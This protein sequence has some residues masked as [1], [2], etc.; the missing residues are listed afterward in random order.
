MKGRIEV[1]NGR[2]AMTRDFGR[3]ATS[4][5]LTAA[6]L[7]W[8]AGAH[9]PHGAGQRHAIESGG[10][11][12]AR[13]LQHVVDA[14]LAALLYHAARDRL[15]S[16]PADWRDVLKSA[17]LTARFAHSAFRDSANQVIDV[18]R[19]IG[20]PVTLLKGISIGDQ[21]YPAPHLR[22]MG[23]I[24]LLLSDR[25][26]PLV[27][28]TLLRLGFTPKADFRTGEGDPHGAP[29]LDPRRCVWIELHTALFHKK[30]R[31]NANS[32][33]RVDN[34]ARRSLASRFDGRSILRLSDELQLVYI[35]CYWLRDVTRN[36]MHPT[37]LIPVFD[38]IF[39][40]RARGRT[41]D[42][43][44]LLDSLDN[45]IAIASLYVL[46]AQVRR[47]GFDEDLAP[48]VRR[49]AVRQRIVGHAELRILNFLLESVLVTGKRFMGSFGDRH[50]M[51]ES[52]VMETLLMPGSFARK[53]LCLPWNV[54][55]PPSVPERYSVAYHGKR[56][57]RLLKR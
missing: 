38:A 15:A 46:L 9:T 34:V 18:C 36:R 33:F 14:G 48:V 40:L 2:V 42:W 7:A 17:E 26:Y 10:D 44:G 21:Y 22:A 30:A 43:D 5:G 23:D 32:L 37:L 25:D 54:V 28:S 4:R 31:V 29:L 41:L 19:K 12:D 16:I 55:F 47:Y 57:A 20:A 53:L 49:L 52:S 11:I 24:D 8:A 45:E 35:A 13:E 27:E 56:V 1:T 50:P 51:I 3:S 6:L 39:I